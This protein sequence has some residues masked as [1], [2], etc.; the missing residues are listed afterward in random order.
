MTSNVTLY[1]RWSY[2][3]PITYNYIYYYPNGGTGNN[4]TQNKQV[5][6]FQFTHKVRR[7]IRGV[8]IVLLAGTHSRTALEHL[9]LLGKTTLQIPT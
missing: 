7:G 1:A 9:I 6:A 2:N 4:L 3:P 5:I 8:V